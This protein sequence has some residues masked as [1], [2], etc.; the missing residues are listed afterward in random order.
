MYLIFK[1]V[2]LEVLAIIFSFFPVNYVVLDMED[3]IKQPSPLLPSKKISFLT[4]LR[5]KIVAWEGGLE[6]L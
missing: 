1:E 3:F 2:I 6:I 5:A 4:A